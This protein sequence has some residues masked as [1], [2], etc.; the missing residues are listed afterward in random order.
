LNRKDL[1]NV[2]K[3]LR[4]MEIR[5][6]E[7]P[8]KTLL[9]KHIPEYRYFREADLV[10]GDER[11]VVSTVHKAKGLQFENVVVPECVDDIYPWWNSE[12]DEARTED[13]RVLYVAMTRA[14]KRLILSNHTI[15]VNQ[16]GRRFHKKRSPFLRCVESCF[17]RMDLLPL[18]MERSERIS[19]TWK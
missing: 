6:A 11:I 9:K 19:G 7:A 8:L 2:A 1:G 12:T 18:S 13:A 3:L 10:T 15:S 5:C 14:M 4:H 16:W 17:R